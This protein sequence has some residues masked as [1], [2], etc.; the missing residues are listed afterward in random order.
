MSPSLQ[1]LSSGS[2]PN[3]SLTPPKAQKMLNE[4]AKSQGI[5]NDYI[6][7]VVSW[8]KERERIAISRFVNSPGLFQG[9]LNSSEILLQK[10]ALLLQQPREVRGWYRNKN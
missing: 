6:F 10:L 3:L 8:R 2:K 5:C 9:F 4:K 7:Y 1:V